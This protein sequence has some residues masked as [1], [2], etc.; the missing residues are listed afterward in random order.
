MLIFG[1]VLAA[2]FTAT[3]AIAQVPEPPQAFYGTAEVNGSPAPVGAQVEARGAGVKVGIQGNPI[4]VTVAGRYGGRTIAE[5]K[6][7]VQGSI[8][9]NAPIE[10]F[11]DGV[12]AQVAV[13]GGEWQDSYAYQAGVVTELNLRVAAETPPTSTATATATVAPVVV[14]P[15]STPTQQPAQTPAVNPSPTSAVQASTNTPLPTA[16][17][18]TSTLVPATPIPAAPSP[19]PPTAGTPTSAPVVA[20]LPLSTTPSATNPLPGSAL[21]QPEPATSPSPPAQLQA[22]VEPTA[23]GVEPAAQATTS[24]PTPDTLAL[25]A[26]TATSEPR[27]EP[28]L[29]VPRPTRGP[30]TQDGLS[31]GGLL[32]IIAIGSLVAALLVIA[33]MVVLVLRAKG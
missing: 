25:V 19:T 12:K 7:G 32:A 8:Q 17:P 4:Q 20:T 6:L 28:P 3:P 9:T 15:T 31:R 10:F 16:V 26:P 21:P 5:P 22:A 33:A 1:A 29:R 13:P 30:T 18:A 14:V 11:V 24:T 2:T 23:P 27:S